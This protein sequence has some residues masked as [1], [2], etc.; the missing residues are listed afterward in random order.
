MFT[1]TLPRVQGQQSNISFVE[2]WI[3]LCDSLA[4]PNLN[5]DL[6]VLDGVPYEGTQAQEVVNDIDFR[7]ERIRIDFLSPDSLKE[8]PFPHRYEGLVILLNSRN[9][10]M[11]RRKVKSELQELQRIFEKPVYQQNRLGHPYMINNADSPHLMVND[12]SI[13]KYD[14]WEVLNELKPSDIQYIDFQKKVPILF[15]GESGKNGLVSIWLKK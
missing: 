2:Q 13:F 9:F 12:S 15:Y 8:W 11:K 3:K 7:K 5:K 6:Y 10:E 4:K 14:V 1:L